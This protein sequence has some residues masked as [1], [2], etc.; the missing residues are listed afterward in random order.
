MSIFRRD[1]EPA[2]S[3][4]STP[5]P[6]RSQPEATTTIVARGSKLEGEIGG[7]APVHVAGE[8]HGRID[9]EQTVI[10]NPHGKVYGD[11]QA[12]IAQ[13]AGRV[14]GNIHGTERV[15][16]LAS[17]ALTGDISAP[18]VTIAEGAFFKGQVEMTGE[19]PAGSG[20]GKGR[21]TGKAASAPSGSAPSGDSQSGD[22]T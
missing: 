2:T 5:T 4:S 21:A 6:G 22:K 15:E 3:P 10:V 19:E 12:R 17:G 1:E 8:F 20:G 14:E 18:R 16:I 9:V 7:G 13:V 11:I